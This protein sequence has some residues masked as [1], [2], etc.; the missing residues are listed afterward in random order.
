MT[1]GT[2]G[3]RG[4]RGAALEIGARRVQLITEA[5]A[6]PQKPN[7]DTSKFFS[8]TCAAVDAMSPELRQYVLKK[9]K[10]AVDVENL[11]YRGR[12]M[13]GAEHGVENTEGPTPGD[14][15]A[16]GRGR[17]RVWVQP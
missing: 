3:K 8:G 7:W 1:N 15:K 16:K 9:A 11:R 6:K 5:C 14:D 4:G 2:S 13:N 10:G 17:G 12:G